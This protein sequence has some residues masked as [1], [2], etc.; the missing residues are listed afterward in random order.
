M[1]PLPSIAYTYEVDMP[2]AGHLV[3][4]L[5]EAQVP[6][7]LAISA[8]LGWAA[9]GYVGA[10]LALAGLGIFIIVLKLQARD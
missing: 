2:T 4:G 10:A 9:I 7:M 1:G 5:T 8:G 6:W 3:T